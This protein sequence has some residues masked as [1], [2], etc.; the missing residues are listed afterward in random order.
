[1]SYNVANPDGVRA[2]ATAALKR[3]VDTAF[4]GQVATRCQVPISFSSAAKQIMS[5]SRH[6]MRDD[7]AAFKVVYSAGHVPSTDNYYER[8]PQADTTI[9]L[10][11]E[12]PAGVF[13]RVKWNGNEYGLI[14]DKGHL[15][16]DFIE[17]PIPDGAVFR[18]W[19]WLNNSIGGCFLFNKQCADT[20][21]GLGE[22]YASGTTVTDS[23]AGV[24]FVSTSTTSIVLP[25]AIIAYTTKPS[26]GLVGDSRIVGGNIAPN[27]TPDMATNGLTGTAER[28]IGDD[29]PYINIGVRGDTAA[30]FRA[31]NKWRLELLK[32]VTSVIYEY[33]INDVSAGKSSTLV[34]NDR[35]AILKLVPPG[36][37]V[38]LQTITPLTTSTDSWATTANQAIP[39]AGKETVRETENAARRAVP[40]GFAGC[41]DV[42]GVLETA[43]TGGKGWIVDGTAFYATGDGTHETKVGNTLVK[44]A[45]VINIALL[46]AARANVRNAPLLASAIVNHQTANLTVKPEQA[47]EVFTNEGATSKPV[48]TLPTPYLGCEYTYI[49]QDVDGLRVT[50]AT[51]CTIRIAASVSA[52]AGFIES[53][54]IGNTVTILAINSTEWVATA[55]NGTWTVT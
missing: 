6:V 11:V 43:I 53:T 29:L 16:S 33:G 3:Y 44:A 8:G 51:G 55:V 39:S 23:S 30:S 24:A 37:P 9:H 34:A 27:D 41:F 28:A 54:T 26:V 2:D 4:L 13:T 32:H 46:Q 15:Y 42:A 12:Y 19:P 22:F 31:T 35:N 49:V 40:T 1:M 50:A 48:F 20:G 21:D 47:G 25:S 17:V 36:K 52:A 7:A 38:Y 18:L 5:V 10:S 14:P 45:G